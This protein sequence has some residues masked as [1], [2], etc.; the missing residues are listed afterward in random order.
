M[1]YQLTIFRGENMEIDQAKR[2]R[3]TI[4]NVNAFIS[5]EL[6]DHQVSHGQVEYFI[7]IYFNP[8]LTQY[9]LSKKLLVTKASV[10]KALKVL[11]KEGYV[12]R[13][14]SEE[15]K[16]E[17]RCFVTEEGEAVVKEFMPKANVIKETLFKGFSTEE[18][19]N[20]MNLTM[21]FYENSCD[22]I[23]K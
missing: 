13:V 9:E 6:R 8:G 2:L 4:Q 7:T 18:I 3:A 17:L 11:E 22:L 10:T 14:S 19:K 16:R 15:D 1:V 23:N 5:R 21:R 12:K 20:Y